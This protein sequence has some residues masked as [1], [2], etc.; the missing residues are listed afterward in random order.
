VLTGQAPARCDCTARDERA[1]FTFGAE[2]KV[3][4][5]EDRVDRERIVQLDDIDVRRGKS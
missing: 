3:L 2:A 1:A 4:E 5:E